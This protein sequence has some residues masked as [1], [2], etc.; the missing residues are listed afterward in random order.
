MDN[1]RIGVGCDIV[2]I[3]RIRKANRSQLL[4]I[5]YEDEIIKSS[6]ESI[7]GLLAAKESC[8]KVFNGL[9]W[10]DIKISKNKKGR[11]ILN[12]SK[13]NYSGKILSSDLSISHDG[14]Y[15]IATVVFILK[16]E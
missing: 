11:P 7:A 1:I 2:E 15:A 5:F 14:L 16:G 13:K 10:H 9:R 6:T 3:E 8:R 12:I 4:K